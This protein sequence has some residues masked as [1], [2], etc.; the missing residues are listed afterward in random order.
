M[1]KVGLCVLGGGKE[2]ESGGLGAMDEEE[3][4]VFGGGSDFAEELRVAV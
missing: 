2:R 3:G 1:I 4:L